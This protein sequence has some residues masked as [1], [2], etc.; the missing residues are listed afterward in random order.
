M[1]PFEQLI[2]I[3]RPFGAAQMV[4]IVDIDA[5]STNMALVW[6]VRRRVRFYHCCTQVIW[7]YIALLNYKVLLPT[8]STKSLT[9]YSCSTPTGSMN[10]LNG[11]KECKFNHNVTFTKKQLTVQPIF[12]IIQQKSLPFWGIHQV[13]NVQI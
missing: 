13:I 10:Y 8:L 2:Y 6:I 4:L 12:D 3:T 9:S 5:I 11:V 7:H 1:T